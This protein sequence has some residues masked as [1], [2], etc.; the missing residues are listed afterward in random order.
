MPFTERVEQAI[1]ETRR[2][3]ALRGAI[4]Q[5]VPQHPPEYIT[6]EDD[7]HILKKECIA[8]NNKNI[9]TMIINEDGSRDLKQSS[10]LVKQDGSYETRKRFK[11]RNVHIDEQ[12]QQREY[13]APVYPAP[14]RYRGEDNQTAETRQDVGLRRVNTMTGQQQIVYPAA[15]GWTITANGGVGVDIYAQTPTPPTF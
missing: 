8:K 10:F 13:P 14:I 7:M 9:G 3:R 5:A 11:K 12:L 1:I 6:E 15:Q 4:A 2:D